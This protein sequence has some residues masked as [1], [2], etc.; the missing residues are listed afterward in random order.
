MAR[1]F[2]GV[3]DKITITRTS[4]LDSLF[5]SSAFSVAFMIKVTGTTTRQMWGRKDAADPGFIG[6]HI[7]WDAAG[8]VSFYCGAGGDYQ[9]VFSA[10]TNLNNGN[11]RPVVFVRNGATIYIFVDGAQDNSAT[12]IAGTGTDTDLFLGTFTS[13]SFYNGILG[14]FAAWDVALSAEEIAA[15]AKSVPAN[16]I[17]STALKLYLPLWGLASPEA[18]VSGLAQNGA[19]TGALLANH[20]P[21]GRYAPCRF[22]PPLLLITVEYINVTDSGVGTDTIVGIEEWLVVTDTGLGTDT[23]YLLG[24]ILIDGLRLDHALR[25]RVSEP[26]TIASRSVSTGLPTRIYL[27]KQGRTLEIEGWVPTIAELNALA[28]LADGAVHEIQLPTG[29][30]ISVHIP[31]VKPVRPIEPGQYP[32][33]IRAVERMD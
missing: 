17:R 8:K 23:A 7:N 11:W 30:R 31:E 29:S 2:D 12:R 15:L 3:D 14:E 22:R 21:I 24:E 27:G 28:A 1:S 20:P 10:S 9:A 13:L 4:A 6:G 16:R 19:V 26:T 33:T 32:Y 25:I 18:D 5:H